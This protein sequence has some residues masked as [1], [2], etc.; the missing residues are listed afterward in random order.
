MDLVKLRLDLVKMYQLLDE[1]TEYFNSDNVLDEQELETIQ[2]LQVIIQTIQLKIDELEATQGLTPH[3]KNFKFSE[4][5]FINRPYYA[6]ANG[7][8][9]QAIPNEYWANIQELM[10]NLEVIRKELGNKPI[11]INSGYRNKEHNEAVGGV[12]NSQ[13]LKGKAADFRVSGITPLQLKSTVIKLI[14]DRKIRQGGVGLYSTY[15]H[16]DIRGHKAR[17]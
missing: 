6:S 3:S 17:W 16:Y 2:A 12:K 7:D 13:H 14:N 15:I 10:D 8:P 9:K 5:V 11:R 4:F 1:Y